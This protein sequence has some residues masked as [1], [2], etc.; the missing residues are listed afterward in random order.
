VANSRRTIIVLSTEYI[1]AVWT[2]LEFKAAHMQAMQD[3]M[4]RIIIITHGSLPPIDT[5][6]R[7]LQRYIRLNTYLSSDDKYFWSKLRYAL[8]RGGNIKAKDTKKEK[9][10][11]KHNK[12]TMR[13]Q[14]GIDLRINFTKNVLK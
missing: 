4:Q 2:K 9:K 12:T 5:L 6:D 11:M 10:K 13:I 8:P 14:A 1:E 3:K 7:D